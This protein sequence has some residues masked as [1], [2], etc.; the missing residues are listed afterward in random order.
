VGRLSWFFVVVCACDKG[1]PP[2]P[3]PLPPAPRAIDAGPPDVAVGDAIVDAGPPDPGP[4]PIR[5]VMIRACNA[6]KYNFKDLSY[7]GFNEGPLK[8]GACTQYRAT[9]G[10]Y[11]YTNAMFHIGKDLFTIEPID[12]VGETPLSPG[13]WSYQITIY[14]YANKGAD[15]RAKRD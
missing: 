4:P 14:D 5:D 8:K 10:A 6:T 11:G 2:K 12:Y 9:G 7:H 13:Q 3:A 15:I 1:A